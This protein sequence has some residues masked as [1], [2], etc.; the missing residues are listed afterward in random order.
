MICLSSYDN[1]LDASKD[2]TLLRTPIMG[3]ETVGLDFF[4]GFQM[5]LK[6]ITIKTKRTVL[7]KNIRR[8]TWSLNLSPRDSLKKDT[9]YLCMYS[10]INHILL[11]KTNKLKKIVDLK[12]NSGGKIN[13]N[14]VSENTFAGVRK[15]NTVPSYFPYMENLCH[16]TCKH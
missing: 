5:F 4:Y 14:N 7:D 8:S 12:W 1:K 16:L 6:Q 15:V 10:L 2:T 9:A 13:A 11:K 3:N